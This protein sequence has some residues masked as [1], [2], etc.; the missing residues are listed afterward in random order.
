MLVSFITMARWFLALGL[1]VLYF[2]HQDTWFWDVA[3]PL[4]FGFLPIGL[5][6]HAVYTVA[7]CLMMLLLIRYAWPLELEHDAE[8][9]TE[10]E[11]VERSFPE[12]L[13]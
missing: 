9:A 3:R 2:L 13:Q 5:F 8:K 11:H 7:I 12:D 4:V 6:Y 10:S 1:V